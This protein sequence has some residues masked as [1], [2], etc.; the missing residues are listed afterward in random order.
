MAEK[1]RGAENYAI[2]ASMG[3]TVRH[4]QKLWVRFKNTPKIVFHA[5]MGRPAGERPPEASSRQCLPPAAPSDPGRAGYGT[6]SEGQ[7]WS[8]SGVSYTPYCGNTTA[9]HK[10]KRGRRKWVRYGHTVWHADYKQMDGGRWLISYGD[11]TARFATGRGVFDRLPQGTPW[12]CW[13]GP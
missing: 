13:T 5:T 10:R 3:M 6:A 12:R 7:I 11:D 9:P 8:F 1:R 4:V 2:A